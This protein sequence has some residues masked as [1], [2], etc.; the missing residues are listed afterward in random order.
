VTL[1]GEFQRA[2][3]ADRD[4]LPGG[5]LVEQGALADVLQFQAA[6]R[7]RELGLI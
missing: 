6:L 7:A 5:A 1:N 2:L 3:I 4:A